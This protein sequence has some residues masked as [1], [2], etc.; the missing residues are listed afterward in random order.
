[1]SGIYAVKQEKQ[2]LIFNHIDNTLQYFHNSFP[3]ICQEPIE[4]PD[5]LMMQ[6]FYAQGYKEL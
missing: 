2:I 1:M 5:F 4:F 6:T 3:K